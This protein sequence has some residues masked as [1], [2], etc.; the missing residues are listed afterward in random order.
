MPPLKILEQPELREPTLIAAFAGW[1]D[2]GSAATAAAQYLIDRWHAHQLGEIDSQEFYDFTQL[3]PMVRYTEGTY[4]QIIWPQNNFYYHQTPE[5][6]LIIFNG[7]E[8]HLRWKNY[9]DAM[10]EMI[11]RFHV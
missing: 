6:D 11:D 1:S 8:P 9:V 4:R 2:A 3:R 10:L 5:R 7:I